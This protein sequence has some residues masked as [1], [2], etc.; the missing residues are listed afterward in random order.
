V[1]V[2][3][4]AAWYDIWVGAYWNRRNKVLY[5]MVP[6]VGIAISFT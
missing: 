6:L 2:R 5:L 3:F 4:V 1:R